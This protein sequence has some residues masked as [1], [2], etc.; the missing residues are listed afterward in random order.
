ML[1]EDVRRTLAALG[2]TSLDQLIGRGDLLRAR[3]GGQ[4]S[5]IDIASLTVNVPR[6]PAVRR[7]HDRDSRFDSIALPDEPGQPVVIR[8]TVRNVDRAIGSALAGE[9]T[10]RFGAAGLPD[11]SI[12]LDLQGSA[13]QSLG[14]FLVP[15][16]DIHLQGETNDYAGKGMHGGTITIRPANEQAP[17][18]DVVAGNAVLYGATGGAIFLRGAAGERFAV[19]N[20]GAVAVVEGI[21]DHGCEYMTGG[22]V[23]NLGFTGRNFGSGM[24]G[25]VAY[26]LTTATLGQPVDL[27][28]W[29]LI[30]S[31]LT[32]HWQLTGSPLAAS[33]LGEGPAAAT[34]FRKLQ[35]GARSAA[36]TGGREAVVTVDG[37]VEVGN[38][39]VLVGG[40]RNEN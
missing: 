14:A 24:T 20:S 32:R 30:E 27:Q 39:D 12:V 38:G 36:E 15:G 17:T 33:L 18:G 16:V 22:A 4:T 13:G 19:R 2:L 35:P 40:V 10:Q 25:G 11:H 6:L 7:G 9:I 34:R 3:T 29:S 1:A 21:G 28:D 37:G 5:A 23:V 8:G 31:L 26:V